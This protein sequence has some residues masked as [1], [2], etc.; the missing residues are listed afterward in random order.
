[1]FWLLYINPKRYDSKKHFPDVDSIY[2]RA[3]FYYGLDEVKFYPGVYLKGGLNF[4]FGEYNT[5]VKSLEVGVA[6][7][8]YPIPIPVVA[9]IP[10]SYYFLTAYLNF[11]F[12][13]RYNKY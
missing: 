3:P 5:R 1:M 12:G 6:V 13:K 9:N 4:E 7:D 2:D 10:E 11:T 8:V